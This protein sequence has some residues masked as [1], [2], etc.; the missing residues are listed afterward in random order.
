MDYLDLLNAD[1]PY[2]EVE[3]V[4]DYNNRHLAFVQ[5]KKE[6]ALLGNRYTLINSHYI[7]QRKNRKGKEEHDRF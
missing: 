3:Y 4:D 5:D 1:M 6:V 2:F 7:I